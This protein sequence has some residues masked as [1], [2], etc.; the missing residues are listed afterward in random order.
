MNILFSV[1]YKFL[2]KC[3]EAPK[4]LYLKSNSSKLFSI[5]ECNSGWIVINIKVIMKIILKTY[6]KDII[7]KD[8]CI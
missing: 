4:N 5:I 6:V 2:L 7:N 1:Y 3:P 8:L